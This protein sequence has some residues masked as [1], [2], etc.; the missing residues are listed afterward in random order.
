MR[1]VFEVEKFILAE[2]PESYIE[3]FADLT[4]GALEQ[5][6]PASSWVGLVLGPVY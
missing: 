5:A 6:S 4:A 1:T 2:T 3:A